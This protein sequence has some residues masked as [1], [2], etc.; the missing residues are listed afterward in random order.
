[1]EDIKEFLESYPDSKFESNFN[2]YTVTF[3]N[4]K[5][6]ETFFHFCLNTGAE[7]ISKKG[8]IKVTF[9]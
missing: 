6:A 8:E 5:D 4:T 9:K 7:M 1:M 2:S 3:D